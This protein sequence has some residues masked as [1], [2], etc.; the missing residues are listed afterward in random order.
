MLILMVNV[1]VKPGRRDEFLRV[2]RDDGEGTTQ[3]E[4]GNFQFS[5]VQDNEDPDKFFLFEVYRDEAALEAHRNMPH[6][7]KYRDATATIYES[8]PIRKM[9]TNVYPDDSYWMG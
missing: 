6:F 3:N 7:R 9:G 4:E 5:C 1:K 8:D 2:I